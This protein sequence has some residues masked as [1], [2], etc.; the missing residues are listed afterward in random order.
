MPQYNFIGIVLNCLI[1]LGVGYLIYYLQRRQ[2]AARQLAAENAARM[3]EALMLMRTVSLRQ[4]EWM[5]HLQIHTAWPVPPP[6][7]RQ[8]PP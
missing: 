6:S 5:E 2:R 8:P 7:T 3:T 1:S 4:L